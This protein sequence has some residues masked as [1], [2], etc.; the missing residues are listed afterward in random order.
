MGRGSGQKTGTLGRRAED[1]AYRYLLERG[2]QPVARNFRRRGGE[3]DIVMLDG[4]SLV[5]IE[6]R[7]RHDASFAP[8]A[9]TVNAQ[10][11]RKLIRTAALFAAAHRSLSRC[12]MRFDV[13]AIERGD[14]V[15]WIR[16]A[17]RPDDSAL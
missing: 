7:Y 4:G 16:D 6:V 10:K 8:P 11:Q 15:R 13:V 3:I 12:V 2:L 14:R 5:F 1:A 17:F 9:L